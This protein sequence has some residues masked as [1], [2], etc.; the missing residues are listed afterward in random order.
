VRRARRGERDAVRQASGEADA[1][2]ILGLRQ[3]FFEA[4]ATGDGFGEVG[5]GDGEGTT[6]FGGEAGWLLVSGHRVS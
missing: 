2:A 5:E 6:G 3:G 4:A 1:E